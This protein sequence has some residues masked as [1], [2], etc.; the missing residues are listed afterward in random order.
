MA[1]WTYLIPFAG[2]LSLVA[3]TFL[4]RRAR[5]QVTP[6]V[7]MTVHCTTSALVF[8][9]MALTTDT[10]TPPTTGSFWLATLWLITFSTFGG[11]GLYWPVV[12]Q[13]SG[14]TEV[15]TLMFLMAPVT[16]VWGAAMFGEPFS[17]QTALGLGVALVAVGVGVVRGASS[18]T[19]SSRTVGSW[20]GETEATRSR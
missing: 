2:M 1:W 8:T 13:R 10:A 9:T 6:T 17:A 20:T 14:V 5:T 19:A 7:S 18:R 4:D 11:Y 16:A 15:N 12:L 3:A